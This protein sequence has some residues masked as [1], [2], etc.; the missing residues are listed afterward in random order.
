M[1]IEDEKK[2]GL[3]NGGSSFQIIADQKAEQD[4]SINVYKGS[5]EMSTMMDELAEDAKK[6]KAASA[7]SAKAKAATD[8]K[9]AKTDVTANHGEAL[10]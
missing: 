9:T 3:D 1:M 7:K 6:E 4:Y 2:E 8:A 10:I 5:G